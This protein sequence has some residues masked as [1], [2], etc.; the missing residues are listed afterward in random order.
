MPA[1]LFWRNMPSLYI[2]S[3]PDKAPDNVNMLAFTNDEIM[4]VCKALPTGKAPSIDLLTYKHLK[5]AGCALVR[6]LTK[7]FNSILKHV[8]TGT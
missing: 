4:N 5:Y 8:Y 1:E 7:L 2:K 3:D 6:Y